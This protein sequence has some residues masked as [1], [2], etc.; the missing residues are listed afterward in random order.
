LVHRASA[1]TIRFGINFN[2]AY[3]PQILYKRFQGIKDDEARRLRYLTDYDHYRNKKAALEAKAG[4]DKQ[5]K[6]RENQAK[7]D[8]ASGKYF[9]MQS[10]QMHR[11]EVSN[12]HKA[13]MLNDQM[14]AM[15]AIQNDLFMQ[16]SNDLQKLYQTSREN[17][18]LQAARAEAEDLAK[19]DSGLGLSSPPVSSRPAMGFSAHSSGQGS[20]R[21]NSSMQSP[22]EDAKDS[23]PQPAGGMGAEGRKRVR[24]LFGY[25]ATADIELDMKEGDVITVL[26]ED[27]S[28]WWQGE[29]DGKVGWFPFNYVEPI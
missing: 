28:G 19:A 29:I 27:D 12:K 11:I 2:S 4:A 5:E 13:T 7:L 14:L 21:G 22:W 25:D 26:R 10:K 24:C 20:P 6:L 17:K 1:E 16:A 18:Y 15:I 23:T 9:A 3:W 8:L